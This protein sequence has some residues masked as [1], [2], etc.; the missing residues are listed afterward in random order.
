MSLANSPLA[1]E[2]DIC[3]NPFAIATMAFL[4]TLE[5][6]GS[7]QGRYQ[8][9][10]F[11]LL[12]LY[13]RGLSRETILVLFEFI[14]IIMALPEE[15]DQALYDEIRQTSEDKQMSI[16]AIAERKGREEGMHLVREM[17]SDVLEIKF[18]AAG[19]NLLNRIAQIND[20]AALQKIRLAV[21]QAQS[22]EQAERMILDISTNDH[23]D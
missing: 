23:K 3:Y 17:I 16:L 4:K 13:R 9:K 22:L 11:F 19:M 10:K 15:L 7:N 12:E 18:G 14:G 2:A 21:K 20:L 8:W 6:K 5:T 1:T